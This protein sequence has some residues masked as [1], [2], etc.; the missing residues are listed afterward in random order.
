MNLF[1]LEKKLFNL[2]LDELNRQVNTFFLYLLAQI[3][4]NLFN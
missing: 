4:L 3:V 2:Q 1:V